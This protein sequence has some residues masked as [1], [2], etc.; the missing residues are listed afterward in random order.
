MYMLTLEHVS[1]KAQPISVYI[2]V[3]LKRMS[4]KYCLPH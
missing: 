2:H 3:L 1:I 4:N